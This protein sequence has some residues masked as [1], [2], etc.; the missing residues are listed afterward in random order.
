MSENEQI[1]ACPKCG[2][3]TDVLYRVNSL[4]ETPGQFWCFK[5]CEAEEEKIEKE[6]IINFYL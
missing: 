6:F 4:G 2:Q 5:C 3:E 1:L